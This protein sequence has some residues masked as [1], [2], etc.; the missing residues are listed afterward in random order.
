[1]AGYSPVSRKWLGTVLG[2]TGSIPAPIFTPEPPYVTPVLAGATDRPVGR[3]LHDPCNFQTS[4][5]PRF[6]PKYATGWWYIISAHS[7]KHS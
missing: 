4:V 7:S 6:G 5:K 3:K 2:S 1:M